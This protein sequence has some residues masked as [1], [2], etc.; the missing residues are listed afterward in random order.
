MSNNNAK[1]GIW[2]AYGW[3]ELSRM[4]ESGE[5]KD[6][7]AAL[8]VLYS[9]WAGCVPSWPKIYNWWE[10]ERWRRAA[11]ENRCHRNPWVWWQITVFQLFDRLKKTILW[12]LVHFMILWLWRYFRGA[13]APQDNFSVCKYLL[14]SREHVSCHRSVAF[15]RFKL[16][17]GRRLRSKWESKNGNFK[18]KRSLSQIVVDGKS[19]HIVFD[20]PP[21][22][23]VSSA[24]WLLIWYPVATW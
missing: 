8:H 2:Y 18:N 5:I 11:T 23:G 13:K 22:Q 10:E 17:L 16:L 21:Q 6:S 20:R 12:A 19:N 1:W 24:W 7:G 4:S 9:F 14:P 15:H 3:T